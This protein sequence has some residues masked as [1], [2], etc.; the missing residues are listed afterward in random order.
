MA[1]LETKVALLPDGVAG[2]ISC[3]LDQ[4]S[5]KPGLDSYWWPC[6]TDLGALADYAAALVMTDGI[7]LTNGP[8]Y[9]R[10][11]VPD[12]AY[13]GYCQAYNIIEDKLGKGFPEIKELW[14]ASPQQIRDVYTALENLP[15]NPFSQIYPFEISGS[16]YLAWESL[17]NSH[18]LM[19]KFSDG[20]LARDYSSAIPVLDT[21]YILSR[22]LIES[23]RPTFRDVLERPFASVALEMG[24]IQLPLI[25][26]VAV[27]R[28]NSP[29]QLMEELHS[30]K[31]EM[32]EIRSRMAEIERIV[33]SSTTKSS[34]RDIRLLRNELEN[35]IKQSAGH[36][37]S[38]PSTFE[39]VAGLATLDPLAAIG[40][41]FE[42]GLYRL[43][44]RVF[45]KPEL[46]LLSQW[47]EECAFDSV[48]KLRK[49]FK[50]KGTAHE[51][52]IAAQAL[53]LHGTV[54]WYPLRR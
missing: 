22:A 10:G 20:M 42:S 43:P 40:K 3:W 21:G 45:Q 35:T 19:V 39:K 24:E 2:R 38:A 28:I 52:K 16:N 37:I 6:P 27:S 12:W 36:S 54:S 53:Q 18:S 31:D 15:A 33:S 32:G 48:I 23:T 26:S 4:C 41:F 34:G 25:L 30:M 50:T 1:K 46:R 7:V 29:Q 13:W 49:I 8:K 9:N 11:V 14:R 17:A 47:T 44:W 51:W 5:E